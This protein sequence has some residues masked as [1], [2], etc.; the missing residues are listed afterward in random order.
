V[1]HSI[2]Q[3]NDPISET[4]AASPFLVTRKC[5][6][7]FV[8]SKLANILLM[9]FDCQSLCTPLDFIWGVLWWLSALWRIRGKIT[10]TSLLHYLSQLYTIKYIWMSSS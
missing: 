1:L 9:L 5:E 6:C 3:T 4:S 10:I 8:I 7:Y 2:I